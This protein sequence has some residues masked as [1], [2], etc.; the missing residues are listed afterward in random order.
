MKLFRIE[1]EEDLWCEYGSAYEAILN[2]MSSSFPDQAKSKWALD[3]AYVNW[4]GIV[5]LSMQRLL[6]LMKP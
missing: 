1:D 3:K 4:R 2:L 5:T 6:D